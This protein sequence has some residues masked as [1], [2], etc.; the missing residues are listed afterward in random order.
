MLIIY[1]SEYRIN[2]DCTIYG[3]NNKD[4]DQTVRISLIC[5][6]VVRIWHNRFSHGVAQILTYIRSLFHHG[7]NIVGKLWTVGYLWILKSERR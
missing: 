5:T 2:W 3:E 6:F 1:T 7:S 4:A